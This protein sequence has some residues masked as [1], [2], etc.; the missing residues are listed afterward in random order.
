[1]GRWACTLIR[2]ALAAPEAEV[3]RPAEGAEAAGP[4]RP[5]PAAA[6][7]AAARPVRQTGG[8][9]HGFQQASA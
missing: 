8:P 1:R 5:T 6:A 2:A 3:R 4:A 9:Q 7:A